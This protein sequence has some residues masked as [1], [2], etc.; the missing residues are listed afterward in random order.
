MYISRNSNLLTNLSTIELTLTQSYTLTLSRKYHFVVL[1][2]WH[3]KND[4]T[5]MESF[6]AAVYTT[7]SQFL[8]GLTRYEIS[9]TGVTCGKCSEASKLSLLD[10]KKKI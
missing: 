5:G 7:P 8:Q 3:H 4:P 2:R 10:C 6:I 1:L 9:L